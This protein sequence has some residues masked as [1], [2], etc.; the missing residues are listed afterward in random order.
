MEVTLSEEEKEGRVLK[1]D[2]PSGG[3]WEVLV[4]PTWG[5]VK[6]F[7]K[8]LKE[9]YNKAE[10]EDLATA[11][12]VYF[13]VAWSFP[14]ALDEAGLDR[15]DARDIAGVMVPLNKALTPLFEAFRGT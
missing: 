13:S 10:D 3:W 4:N 8:F 2:L 12:L 14:E 5:Q 9:K 6:A 11:A 15:R 7:R 1:V